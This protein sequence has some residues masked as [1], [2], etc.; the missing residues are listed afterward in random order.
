MVAI[1]TEVSSGFRKKAHLNY[2]IQK[3]CPAGVRVSFHR[4]SVPLKPDGLPLELL[5]RNGTRIN[6]ILIEVKSTGKKW[7]S[8]F[9][10]N[11]EFS[12]FLQLRK[13]L[14]RSEKKLNLVWKVKKTNQPGSLIQW[15]SLNPAINWNLD[16]RGP[17]FM[18]R[19][20]WRWLAG[21]R[22]STVSTTG[23]RLARFCMQSIKVLLA[24]CLV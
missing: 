19:F 7:K 4:C 6:P 9:H 1:E 24:H 18:N 23:L 5:N 14:T 13:S 16:P 10:S 21:R 8:S 11:L 20:R 3:P 15:V 2:K 12:I 17:R 22:W